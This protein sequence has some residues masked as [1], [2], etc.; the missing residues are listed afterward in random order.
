MDLK[1]QDRVLKVV[2]G[3]TL[4]TIIFFTNQGKAYTLKAHEI[5]ESTRSSRGTPIVNLLQ[6]ADDERVVAAVPV[7]AFSSTQYL[8]LITRHGNVKRTSLDAFSNVRSTGII[9]TQF[10]EHDSL[11]EALVTTGDGQ[12][13]IAT[14]D[15]L[16]IRFSESDISIMGRTAKGMAGIRLEEGSEVAGAAFLPN[17]PDKVSIFS[18]TK[19]AHGKRTLAQEFRLQKRG[20]AGVV[21][22]NV[23]SKSGNLI[24]VI[25]ITEQADVMIISEKGQA[26]R[27]NTSSIALQRRTTSGSRLA[28]LND[29]DNIASI[30]T[31]QAET[32]TQ[33]TPQNK[34]VKKRK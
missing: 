4:Q 25:P 2:S 31:I 19:R 26:N 9:A 10:D 15:G 20:G 24:G 27:L 29:G 21:G 34:L 33:K 23:N 3:R 14:T 11:A 1:E 13:A 12:I 32:P 16:T 22:F 30:V 7:D 6:L 5:T 17:I 8:T 18:I 28:K